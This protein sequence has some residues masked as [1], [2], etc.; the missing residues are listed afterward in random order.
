MT[1]TKKIIVWAIIT[2]VTTPG[3]IMVCNCNED[4]VYIN[5]IGLAYLWLAEKACE[6]LM[7]QWMKDYINS[8]CELDDE[9]D[10]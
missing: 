2:I 6:R 9:F 8:E 10:D 1:L 3:I 7:P 4:V 5:F